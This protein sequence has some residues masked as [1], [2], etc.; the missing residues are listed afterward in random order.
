MKKEIVEA[1][2]FISSE[3]I[4]MDRLSKISGIHS[5]GHL[6]EI[7]EELQKEYS[8]RGINIIKTSDGWMMN[9]RQDIL[10]AV[11][12]LTPYSDLA[13]G[14]KRTLALVAY[15]EPVKQADIIKIQG[16]KAY[17]YI[18]DL[19]R[20]RLIKS[21]KV[22]HTKI[23]SLTQ[24]FE[25]YFG[26]EKA[27]IRERLEGYAT[28]PE[29]AETKEQAKEPEF[30]DEK[31]ERKRKAKAEIVKTE[32]EEDDED[33][34]EPEEPEPENNRERKAKGSHDHAF[35]EIE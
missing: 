12:H 3:P 20:R 8:G 5:L 29:P 35:K 30:A 23:L 15:K 7:L 27:K 22:G 1:A 10:P 34:E 17:S 18:K 24:E 32:K 31:N 26:E 28:Q 9:V 13:E 11:S 6:K 16:N 4:P 14:Q 2:L 19:V 33:F 21:E 25:R